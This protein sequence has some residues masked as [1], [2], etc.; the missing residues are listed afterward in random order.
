MSPKARAYGNRNASGQCLAYITSCSRTDIRW[1]EAYQPCLC[2]GSKTAKRNPF[3]F[4]LVVFG[5]RNG[6]R[7]RLPLGFRLCV[8]TKNGKP[9]G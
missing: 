4:D 7:S 6:L 1:V 9:K 2:G 5:Y 8:P 3:R